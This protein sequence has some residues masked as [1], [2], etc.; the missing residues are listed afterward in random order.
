MPPRNA[1]IIPGPYFAQNLKNAGPRADDLT[2]G[3]GVDGMS[4]WVTGTTRG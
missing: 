1:F 2:M 3:A 4:A